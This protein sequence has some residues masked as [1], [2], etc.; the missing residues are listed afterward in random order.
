MPRHKV[1][2]VHPAP[3]A[4]RKLPGVAQLP[5]NDASVGMVSPLGAD[6]PSRD[7][8][9]E[10][11]P[12]AFEWLSAFDQLQEPVFVHDQDFRILRCN[13]AYAAMAG[14]PM[15]AIVGKPYWQVF[16]KASGPLGQCVDAR[17]K[18]LTAEKS[19]LTA[20]AGQIFLS[21]DITTH[22]ASGEFWYSR[23]MLENITARKREEDEQKLRA[24]F[25]DAIVGS[26]PGVLLVVDRQNRIVRWNAR[27]KALTGRSDAQL[28]G[29]DIL[30]LV[31]DENR[32]RIAAKLAEAFSSGYAQGEIHV[33]GD[34]PEGGDYV[35]SA[36]R[37]EVGGVPYV[38]SFGVDRAAIKQSETDLSGEKA[39]S[40]TII[41]SAPGPFYM[42]DQQGNLVRWNRH[43]SEQT[44]LADAQ[45]RGS[46]ILS[47]IH[48]QDRPLAA[49]KF[50]AAFA[51]GYAQMEVRVPTADQGVRIF[52]KTARR[53]EVAGVPYVA[54]FC[55]DVT[56]RKQAE[57]ALA[58]EKAFS[59]ALVN[60]V[61]GAFYV[62]DKEGNYFAWNSYLNRLTGL[63]D[64]ELKQR[65]SLLTI[66]EEDRPLAAATMKQAFDS[67]YAQAELH[68]LTRDRGVRLYFMTA[69]R[70]QVADA[71]YLVGVGV[72]TTDRRA[73]MVELEHEAQTDPL[74]QVANRGRFMEVARQE[75]ARARRYGH[76][77]SLWMLDID[78]FKAV[79][80]S[81]GH[82]AGD[83]ALQSLVV[84]SR[85]AL[86]DWDIMARMGGEEFAVLLPETDT[87]QALLVAE[88]LRQTV[89]M[90]GVAMAPGMMTHLTVSIGV[91]SVRDDDR[92]VEALLDRA[93]QALYEAK[94]TGR[95]KVSVAEPRPD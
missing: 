78:H 51:M 21:H 18:G 69:R 46:S 71:T 40:D 15:E 24:A 50:L 75:F 26:A 44:G 27:L 1:K 20:E 91:A 77:L 84:T 54:G 12:A 80:D 70:F 67:G 74:T 81:Y 92:D 47:T 4:K 7:E 31:R 30:S 68:V 72:D 6:N 13:S 53:F 63:S 9:A 61:P 60:S 14:Q 86:R 48:E 2:Q 62:V 39:L 59:D 82:H 64:R 83:V 55:V 88:R 95:D 38:L 19:E 76:P 41:E 37:F 29:A 3:R 34:T 66:Q 5:A 36:Q 87:T 8:P 17:E 28:Q 23:H 94:R 73:K 85:Q 22:K 89:A 10:R 93:D 57:D 11:K 65:T 56:E 45:L 35:F 25:S 32:E 90:A 52:F 49:A 79:N 42:I 58:K 16:P 33:Q 43:L